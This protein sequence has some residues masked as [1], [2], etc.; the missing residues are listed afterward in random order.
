MLLHEFWLLIA[1]AVPVAAV[2]V[3]NL[4]L[5][6]T[7]ERGTLLLPTPASFPAVPMP[8]V[9]E[10]VEPAVP[11]PANAAEAVAYEEIREAA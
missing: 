11:V 10:T 2:V 8:D 9:E 4:A 6:L 5:A 3:V 7:G 1:V